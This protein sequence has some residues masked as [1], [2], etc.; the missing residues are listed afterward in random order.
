MSHAP[1]KILVVD[2]QPYNVDYLQQELEDLHYEI[3]TAMNGEQALAQVEAHA[4]DLVLLDIVMPVMN[5]F[6]VLERLKANPR[7]C[8][9]PV[10]VI[11]AINDLTH[12]AKGISMGAD[13]YLPKPFEPVLLHARINAGLEKKRQRDKELEYLRQVTALTEA[14]AAVEASRFDTAS[15]TDVSAR[16]DALGNLARVFVTMA[17]QVYAREQRLRQQVQ[18]L[19]IELDEARQKQQVAEITESDYFLNLKAKADDLRSIINGGI[20]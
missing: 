20:S 2:D 3:I 4:P 13:D 10:V 5:G 15:L 6:E 1:A 19:R 8:D 12:V 16:P 14:A 11:S 18:A 9:I 17:E 7:W